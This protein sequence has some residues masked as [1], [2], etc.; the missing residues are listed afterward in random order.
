[1]VIRER[2]YST[3]WGGDDGDLW[4]TKSELNSYKGILVG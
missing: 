2:V 1:M 3:M 4:D